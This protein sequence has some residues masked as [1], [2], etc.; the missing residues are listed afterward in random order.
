MA[1]M[2]VARPVT[3]T[4]IAGETGAP[5]GGRLHRLR[6]GLDP[7]TGTP[8]DDGELARLRDPLA[9]LL[10]QR[11]IFPAT[12]RELVSALD[13]AEGPQAV[14]VQ[15]T[16][17]TGEGSQLPWTQE[18]RD[19]ARQLR[20]LVSRGRSKEQ[21][22]LLVTTAPDADSPDAFLQVLAWDDENG[23]FDYYLRFEGTTA[24]IFAGDSNDALEPSTRGQ[25]PFSAHT[26]G[27]VVM[28][29]LREPWNNWHSSR[30]GVHDAI[31]P[32]SPLRTDPLWRDRQNADVF[33]KQVAK[34]CVE[35][36]TGSRLRAI[37]GGPGIEHPDRLLRH[38]LETTTV[39]LRTTDSESAAVD[40][41]SDLALPLTFLF[42][43][44]LLEDLGIDTPGQAPL[45][46]GEHYRASLARYR[47]RLED[48]KGAQ[49]P[50]DTHFAFLFPEPALED[51]EVV[52]QA[53]RSGLLSARFAAC[54]S[55]VDF[56]NPVYS[57]RRAAL[58]RHAPEVATVTDS[59]S[60]L[61]DRTAERI[62]AAAGSLGEDSPEREFARMWELPADQWKSALSEQLKNYLDAA[63]EVAADAD[64]FDSYVRLA[65][66]RRRT[67]AASALNEF[68][69]LLPRTDIPVDMPVL[70]M[71]RDATVGP[72][73][74]HQGHR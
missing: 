45:V 14:P 1:R 44:E 2:D 11:G 42:N 6:T 24:W 47:F 39:N 25:G 15:M 60:D 5:E 74:E 58:M 33:E 8:V 66:S 13:A 68:P 7:P 27:S 30:A 73:T 69:L 21:A 51:N 3:V 48:G 12:L 46:R 54:A 64:G 40:D 63:A 43:L 34:R 52:R 62:T 41:S 37:A 56:P 36:W 55:M 70:A 59:G 4:S 16:F 28:R 31:P 57:K 18:T 22:E 53:I 17:L 38:L 49:W 19:V 50:G 20:C 35:R 67:F 71:R 61:A 29:E 26:N 72:E 65:E 23:V 32:D 10:F 9:V